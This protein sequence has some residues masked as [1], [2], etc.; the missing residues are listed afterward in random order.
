MLAATRDKNGTYLPPGK[1]DELE[2]ALAS[3]DAQ[4]AEVRAAARTGAS[5]RR[6]R[7]AR[8]SA[9]SARRCV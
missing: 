9:E 8:V 5:N 3:R 6:E 1:L 2:D 7:R 4:L